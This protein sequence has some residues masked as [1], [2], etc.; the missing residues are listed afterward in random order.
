MK[1]D[2][3][4][5]VC[6]TGYMACLG[7]AG[8]SPSYIGLQFCLQPPPTACRA[9]PTACRPPPTALCRPPTTGRCLMKPPLL[10]P[11]SLGA[12]HSGAVPGSRLYLLFTT[13]SWSVVVGLGVSSVTGFPACRPGLPSA[14][15]S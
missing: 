14:D 3:S 9:P 8:D 15:L 13:L 2:L 4:A 10:P 7:W 5:A 11:P 1:L 6:V 12:G